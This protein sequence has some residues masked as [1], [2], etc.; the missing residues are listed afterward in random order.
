MLT[1]KLTLK[2]IF[3][4][5]R[6]VIFF[7]KSITLSAVSCRNI[8]FGWTFICMLLMGLPLLPGKLDSYC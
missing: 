7:M 2:R 6:I 5:E 8:E 1:L 4:A 3:L